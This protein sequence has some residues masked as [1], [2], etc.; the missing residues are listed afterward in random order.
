MAYERI[1]F[2]KD[3]ISRI[4]LN[5]PKRRN[6]LSH[7]LCSE[8]LDAL[9]VVENDPE[10]RV[11]ILDAEGPIFSAGHDISEEIPVGSPE[12][13]QESWRKFLTWLRHGWYL[14]LWE[15]PKPIICKV[16][17]V[18]IAGGIELSCFADACLC[19]DESFF[20]YFPIAQMSVAMSPSQIIVWRIGMWKTKEILMGKGFTGKEAAACG[21][22]NKSVPRDQLEDLVIENATYAAK[23]IPDT[24]RLG[25]FV[26]RFIYDR[27][28]V[29]DSIVFGSE[30]DIM[31]HCHAAD[32]P[33]VDVMRKEGVKG[34]VRL[35]QEKMAK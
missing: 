2:K 29:H 1:K 8:V 27:L 33:F 11:I 19:S 18:A 3:V 28:G 13:T 30:M 31:A 24:L 10:C 17:G 34:M 12:P 32:K 26:C 25:K 21:L 35:A 9:Q 14:K 16:D 20:T 22:V 6:A 23:A 7:K 4:T 5:D 15:Y